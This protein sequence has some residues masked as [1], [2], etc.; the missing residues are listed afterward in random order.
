MAAN[1]SIPLYDDLLNKITQALSSEAQKVFVN[2]FV[3]YL[4][5]HA[6]P[7]EYVVDFDDI[8]EWLGFSRR[9]NAI[10]LLKRRLVPDVDY[11]SWA[12]QH[13]GARESCNLMPGGFN[14]ENFMLTIDAFKTLC[15]LADTTKGTEVRSYYIQMEKVL[16]QHISDTNKDLQKQLQDSEC[17][18]AE[19]LSHGL[20]NGNQGRSLCYL[21]EAV[22]PSTCDIELNEGEK[23]YK[24]GETRDI[25]V[26]LPD[27]DRQFGVHWVVI[28]VFKCNNRLALEKHFIDHAKYAPFKYVG[29][30]PRKRVSAECFKFTARHVKSFILDVQKEYTKGK[31]QGDSLAEREL[32]VREHESE[33]ERMR[34]RAYYDMIERGMSP[35]TVASICSSRNSQT[36]VDTLPQAVHPI[37]HTNV[38]DTNGPE[39][40]IYDPNNLSIHLRRFSGIIEATRKISE[41]SHS[42]IKLASEGCFVYR[43]YRWQLMERG[44]QPSP[45]PATLMHQKYRNGMVASLDN[46]GHVTVVKDSQKAWAQH[47]GVHAAAVSMALRNGTPGQTGGVRL[48]FWDNL[49]Q[50]TRDKYLENN[51]L[52]ERR[53]NQKC[54]GVLCIRPD[55]GETVKCYESLTELQKRTGVTAKVVKTCV[56]DAAHSHGGF[57]YV[58]A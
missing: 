18:K 41:T 10:R 7:E 37:A 16:Y 56:R 19:M 23:I 32:A 30:F 21:I 39:V 49:D 12:P 27:L 46:N 3:K 33:T 51:A 29:S 48:A 8:L 57:R 54:K 40:Y 17:Q 43:G 25:S 28:D 4:E 24:F 6:S 47:L 53:S 52:P 44:T 11:I 50:D 22:L 58:F 20:V 1:A 9:D 38:N 45:V 55:T 15:M 5:H 13:G 14:R 36:E 26:R 31:Y 35:E 2:F 42:Q 34:Y